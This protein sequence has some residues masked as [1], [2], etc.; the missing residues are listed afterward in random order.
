MIGLTNMFSIDIDR[1]SGSFVT[2]GLTKEASILNLFPNTYYPIIM[3]F[4]GNS[5]SLKWSRIINYA[6][7]YI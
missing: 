5:N 6:N 3:Y 1:N 7:T 4:D 2:V